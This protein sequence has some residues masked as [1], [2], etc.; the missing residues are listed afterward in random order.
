MGRRFA[1]SLTVG[2]FQWQ[3]PKSA[4]SNTQ[5]IRTIQQ[6]NGRKHGQRVVSIHPNGFCVE[7]FVMGQVAKHSQ[8]LNW[9]DFGTMPSSAMEELW[10]MDS[11]LAPEPFISAPCYGFADWIATG[12]LAYCE[13]HCSAT[14]YCTLKR[15]AFFQG[16]VIPSVPRE[17]DRFFHAL[18]SYHN[19]KFFITGNGICGLG[20]GSLI[21]H[22]VLAILMRCQMSVVLRPTKVPDEYLLVGWC[23]V[24]RFLCNDGIDPQLKALDSGVQKRAII[25]V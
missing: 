21:E 15:H 23:Y 6:L 16:K 19:R 24:R 12:F 4:S 22:D 5:V 7:A 9:S 17:A 1:L 13:T 11:H 8:M 18:R 20:P 14:F 2:V 25:I 3:R 10:S